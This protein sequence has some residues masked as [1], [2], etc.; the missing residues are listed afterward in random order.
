MNHI[1]RNFFVLALGLLLG[2]AA[3]FICGTESRAD[4]AEANDFYIV[5]SAGCTCGNNNVYDTVILG[6]THT[7]TIQM[8]AGLTFEDATW[9]CEPFQSTIDPTNRENADITFDTI[10]AHPI[11]VTV[12]DSEG[13]EYTD[14][15]SIN[16][17]TEKFEDA[18]LNICAK[19]GSSISI[20]PQFRMFSEAY[21]DGALTTITEKN[22]W[23]TS[24]IESMK[25]AIIN[26]ALTF[27]PTQ[28]GKY[29]VSV[30]FA[31]PASGFPD[32][33]TMA[34]TTYTI[35]IAENSIT[36]GQNVAISGTKEDVRTFVPAETGRYKIEWLNS[37]RTGSEAIYTADGTQV[38]RVDDLYGG[39]MLHAGQTYYIL[40]GYTRPDDT[41]TYT[42]H[43]YLFTEDSDDDFSP[44]GQ[45]SQG[46]DVDDSNGNA[47][48]SNTSNGNS[49]MG[50]VGSNT[51]AP[52]QTVSVPKVKGKP[53]LKNKKGKVKLTFKKVKGADGYEI[54]Y[55]TNKKFKKSKKITVKSPKAT[56][57]KLKMGRKYFVKIRAFKRNADSQKVYGAYS[58]VVKINLK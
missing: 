58:K 13:H 4:N 26:D 14:T 29:S 30:S 32:G 16:V 31:L 24:S 27:T 56:L 6:S 37:G 49:G 41:N 15:L 23:Y 54:R 36:A 21:P 57:K 7:Y 40:S 25:P 12:T 18:Y 46:V 19:K 39:Y 35:L 28:S 42:Y 45:P 52:A 43:I 20:L 17:V 8:H 55:A 1:K 48:G 44:S 22:E 50:N 47:A 5:H 33:K 3:L 53:K 11:L 51:T 10:G 38:E 2:T 9:M 34:S